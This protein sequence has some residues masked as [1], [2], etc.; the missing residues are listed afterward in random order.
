[1]IFQLISLDGLKFDGDAYEVLVPTTDG[2]IAVLHNHEPLISALR[3][4]IITVRKKASDSNDSRE[5][6]AAYGG[7]LE[8]QEGGFVRVLVDSAEHSEDINAAEAQKALEAAEKH[9]AEAK[10]QVSL[11]H[12]QHLIDR[13]VVRLNVANLK[14]KRRG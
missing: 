6:F 4:G 12:A 2:D 13:Q 9:K 11:D 1:M 14:I 8:V 10:D 3:P 7:V 5:V